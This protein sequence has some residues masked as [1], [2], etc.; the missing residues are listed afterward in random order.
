MAEAEGEV[1]ELTD[2][3]QDKLVQFQV[4]RSPCK[5]SNEKPKPFLYLAVTLILAYSFYNTCD[6]DFSPDI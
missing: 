5:H 4:S 3:Q 6:R 1:Q 2:E